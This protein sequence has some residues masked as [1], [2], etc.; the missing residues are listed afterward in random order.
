MKTPS[1]DAFPRRVSV[2][3]MIVIR[4]ARTIAVRADVDVDPSTLRALPAERK[5]E[6]IAAFARDVLPLFADGRLRP[7]VDRSFPIAEADA[8]HARMQA[9]EHVGKLVLEVPA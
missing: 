8:A 6:L 5:A 1:Q 4:T 7:L 3:G 9:G 2:G